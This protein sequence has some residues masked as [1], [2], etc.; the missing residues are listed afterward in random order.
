MFNKEYIFVG[1][2]PL[3]SYCYIDICLC[4][5]KSINF[6]HLTKYT[7]K[8]ILSTNIGWQTNT[9]LFFNAE[10]KI[11]RKNVFKPIYTHTNKKI[12]SK[13]SHS[14][15]KKKAA[16]TTIT[17]T[18]C[19]SVSGIATLLSLQFHSILNNIYGEVCISIKDIQKVLLLLLLWRRSK[20]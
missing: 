16:T 1:Y 10:S 18:K 3:R 9:P 8:S 19:Q 4:R 7:N 12:L 13:T 14:K 5:D 15:K 2:A 11:L 20:Y 17:T 6:L